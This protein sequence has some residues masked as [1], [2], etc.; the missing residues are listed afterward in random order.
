M[1][2]TLAVA[3]VAIQAV[4]SLSGDGEVFFLLYNFLSDPLTIYKNFRVFTA[5]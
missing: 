1:L 4:F 5:C 3:N 2:A